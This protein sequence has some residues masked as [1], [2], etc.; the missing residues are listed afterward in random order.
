MIDRAGPNIKPY[1]KLA[2]SIIIAKHSRE[3]KKISSITE[4]VIELICQLAERKVRNTY[5]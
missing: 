2:R 4:D 3:E 5:L 1:K